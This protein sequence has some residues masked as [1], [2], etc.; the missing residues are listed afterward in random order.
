MS[1]AAEAA[2]EAPE[3][4]ADGE[5]VDMDGF[6]EFY[7]RLL[8]RV[9]LARRGL[10]RRLKRLRATGMAYAVLA[11]AVDLLQRQASCQDKALLIERPR[12]SIMIPAKFYPVPHLIA[13]RGVPS[14]TPPGLGE[15]PA[16]N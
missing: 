11:D 3:A 5:T 12:R 10:D 8:S 14:D 2:A 13:L 16:G 9:K 1:K 6:D 4:E 15:C 7:D